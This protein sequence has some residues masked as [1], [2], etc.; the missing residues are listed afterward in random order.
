MDVWDRSVMG[1]PSAYG[2]GNAAAG[3][4]SLVLAGADGVPRDAPPLGAGSL[5]RWGMI[6]SEFNPTPASAPTTSFTVDELRSEAIA[7]LGYD[8]YLDE[9][10]AANIVH[11]GNGEAFTAED[12]ASRARNAADSQV[13]YQ[14]GE[15]YNAL[16]AQQAAAAAQASTSLGRQYSNSF[17]PGT[18]TTFIPGQGLS[19]SQISIQGTSSSVSSDFA[20]GFSGEQRSV[21]APSPSE[22]YRGGQV[23]RFLW[24]ISPGGVIQDYIQNTVEGRPFAAIFAAATFAVP[25][26]RVEG[27]AERGLFRGG[28]YGQ[29]ERVEGFERH[30]LPADSVS[31]LSTYGGPAIQMERTDH[32]LTSSHG[33]Q[34]ISGAEYRA[35]L[36][37]LIQQGQ[38]RDAMAR[39]IWD[40]RRAA[41]EGGGNPAKYNGAL[42]EM[43][44]YSYGRGL[45][46]K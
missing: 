32:I 40:V 14:M 33:F 3:S 31:P 41:V 6:P 28:A 17:P 44:D 15:H 19:A 42:R 38:M 10:S 11:N 13:T 18:Q 22:A 30:H 24:D 5:R 2:P 12:Y 16:E 1:D 23:A 43:L 21:M 27:A 36:Q 45:L 34:G 26:A 8:P 29:L 4:S 46:N 20:S 39:E 35:E 25:E 9:N 37:Q 7:R